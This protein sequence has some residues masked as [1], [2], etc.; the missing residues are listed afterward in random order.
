MDPAEH[1]G[2]M[3]TVANRERMK[4]LSE[5]RGTDSPPSSDRRPVSSDPA[6]LRDQVVYRREPVDR[7]YLVN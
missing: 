6:E 1:H 3:R 5:P 4:W 2:V 7:R